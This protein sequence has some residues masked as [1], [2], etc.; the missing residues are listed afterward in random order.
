MVSLRTTVISRRASALLT[1]CSE[2]ARPSLRGGFG[3][4]Y[5]T[6]IPGI[7]NNRFVDLSPFSPQLVL[8]TGVVKPGYI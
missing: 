4:F 1:T 7:I 8:N 6:R 2:I 3:I 5:D